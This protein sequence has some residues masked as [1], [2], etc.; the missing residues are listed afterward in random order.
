MSG[1]DLLR[2]SRDGDQ[3]HYYWAARQSL[4]LL[5]PGTSLVAIAIEGASDREF[6]VGQ[7]VVAGEQIID[8]AEYYGSEHLADADKVVYRQLKHSTVRRAEPWRLSGLRRTLC[9]FA[10]RYK[11]LNDDTISV[12]DKVRFKL[13]TNRPV[14]E[15]F[16][17]T[18]QDLAQN[19]KPRHQ[20]QMDLLR[21]YIQIHDDS[22]ASKFAQLLDLGTPEIDLGALRLE[23]EN[24]VAEFLPGMRGDAS[25]RL[26]ETVSQRATSLAIDSTIRRE[27]V[28]IALGATE[29]QLFPAPPLLT[30]V[31][32]PVARK[33]FHKISAHIVHAE[34]PVIVHAPGGVGKSVLAGSLQQLLPGGSVCVVYDCFGAG[35]YRRMSGPRHEHRQA[36]VQIVNEIA[37]RRL[38]QPLVPSPTATASD[39]TAAFRDRIQKSAAALRAASPDAVLVIA[40]D[41][42]DNA[43][44][45]AKDFNSGSFV[46]DLLAE[47][48][49]PGN[50]RLAVFARTER[51]D[52]LDPPPEAM[53]VEITGFS[54]QETAEHV[55]MKFADAK[56]LDISEFHRL[57]FGNPRVQAQVLGEATSVE[58]CLRLLAS[59]NTIDAAGT[60]DA[61]IANSV[62]KI[63]YEQKLKLSEVDS[64][65][66]SLAALRP[67]IPINFMAELCS[68]PIETIHSFVSDLGRPLLI[69]GDS[70]QFRDE[71]TETWFRKNHRPTSAKLTSFLL[72]LEPLA[73]KYTYAAACLPQLLWEAGQFAKLVQLAVNGS[74]LPKSNELERAEIEQQRL[75]FA[76]KSAAKRNMK[77]EVAKLALKAGSL[78]LGEARRR[79]LIRNN[80]HI[81]G[82]VLN[83]QIVDDLLARRALAVNWPGSNLAY[84]GCMLSFASGQLDIAR[85]RLRS[86]I[87]WMVGWSRL[88]EDVKD[89]NH[90]S[91]DDIAQV[92]LG[93]VNT[94]GPGAAVAFLSRWRP[95]TV[96]YRAGTIV[97]SRLI[98][99]NRLESLD[100]FV[101][102]AEGN[103]LLQLGI[104]ESAGKNGITIASEAARSALKRFRRRRKPI[105]VS[106]RRSHAYGDE[107][108]ALAAT[109]A[110]VTASA[111]HRLAKPNV[112]GRILKLQL[113]PSLPRG[114]GSRG[115][116][117]PDLLLK[118]FSLLTF[119]SGFE[120]TERNLAHPELVKEIE[121]PKHDP[122]NELSEFRRN[123]TPALP[124]AQLWA[125]VVC[126]ALS[127]SDP[128]LRRLSNDTY[129]KNVGDYQTPR[130]LLQM[131]ARFSAQILAQHQ[132]HYTAGLFHEWIRRVDRFLYWPTLIEIVQHSARTQSMDSVTFA[133]AAHL[134]ETL[135]VSREQASEKISTFAALAR[136]VRSASLEEAKAY[137]GRAIETSMKIGDEVLRRWNAVNALARQGSTVGKDDERAYQL[138]RTFEALAEFLGDASEQQPQCIQTIV[139]F[140]RSSAL[141]IAARWRDRRFGSA[142]HVLREI[143]DSVE[144]WGDAPL[145]V[146]SLVPISE[147]TDMRPI[148]ERLSS[149][150][151]IEPALLFDVVS[152]YDRGT[153]HHPEYFQ[154]IKSL[155]Q[156][157][158]IDL[159]TTSYSDNS[160]QRRTTTSR[161]Y[162]S[163]VSHRTS[164]GNDKKYLRSRASNI[165]ALRALDLSQP[166]DLEEARRMCVDRVGIN[167]ED[168]IDS[169]LST[170]SRNLSAVIDA[171]RRN[172]NFGAYIYRALIER[173][174]D[175]DG[176]PRAALDAGRLLATH[177]IHRFCEKIVTSSDYEVLPLE[178]LSRATGS[179][180]RDIFDAAL[181][182]LGARNETLDADTCFGLVSSIAPWLTGR[183]ALDCFDQATDELEYLNEIDTGDGPWTSALLPPSDIH[184][185]VAGY[186]WS[187]L[188]DPA[189]ATRWR[190]AH[191]VHLLCQLG[192]DGELRAL[193]DLAATEGSEASFTDARLKF[194]RLHA[195]LWLFLGLER[196]SLD[197][198]NRV[199]LFQSGLRSNA[200]GNHVLLRESARRSLLLLDRKGLVG[201]SEDER[202]HL[203]RVNSPV[204]TAQRHDRRPSSSQRRSTRADG[205]YRF[206]FDFEEHWLEPLARCFALPLESVAQ[207]ASDVITQSWAL[208][209]VDE[210]V[211]DSRRLLGI[212]DEKTSYYKSETPA[213]HAL[214]FYLSFHA[215]MVVAG[216]LIDT[217][218]VHVDPDGIDDDF[219]GWLQHFRPTRRDGRWLS[220][221]RDAIPPDQVSLQD[222]DALDRTWADN[223][224]NENPLRRLFDVEPPMIVVSEWSTQRKDGDTEAVSVSS[225]LVAPDRALHLLAAWQSAASPWHFAVPGDN[226]EDAL[227]AGS[228]R[229]L[230]WIADG[231]LPSRLDSSD[232]LA[233]GV[234]FPA[235]RPSAL[236]CRWLGIAG[237][238]DERNWY[239]GDHLLLSSIVWSDM[240]DVNGRGTGTDGHR[241]SISLDGLRDLTRKSGMS[242]IFK[243]TLERTLRDDYKH[244]NGPNDPDTRI[245]V[246]NFKV[247][248]F[249]EHD[250]FVEL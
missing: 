105:E 9:G 99:A 209:L 35:R 10:D 154:Q 208:P 119:F 1:T 5:V 85:S 228:Y 7:R 131:V 163:G 199:A 250:G 166:H 170:P 27:D 104:L 83:G 237:D 133:V 126:A 247:L 71:P 59:S 153:W 200:F 142:Y 149:S 78:S 210:R 191:S 176:L 44:M 58:E 15:Q 82:E 165:A 102:A 207:R 162:S 235:P 50:V 197:A 74:A 14:D 70:I 13:V 248:I 214:D 89:D 238:T 95:A 127:E 218:P 52:L 106:D 233:E 36:L 8:I 225:A 86:A 66:E 135:A 48:E 84:E 125:R 63:R 124:W 167:Y 100:S 114:I 236:A 49:M 243:V 120:M 109:I 249:D 138:A 26:K 20:V 113:P 161:P 215:L 98:E 32:N 56:D 51:V 143:M 39:Y 123:I 61:V 88:P 55:R 141:A 18:V 73:E 16:N 168:L 229:L 111:R 65:C 150:R 75:Q 179:S 6:P 28:L 160:I 216:D 193:A 69:D 213:V 101:V 192:A 184:R 189:E 2:A 30:P 96:A 178:L 11:A 169:T 185:C 246:P 181:I 211:E 224:R 202:I 234:Q 201:V 24:G 81:A 171:F 121:E 148:L 3:F 31:L 152:T 38:C 164:W 212:L 22:D 41:A 53:K 195:L 144:L 217:E 219:A 220:D 227:N 194:Y 172:D 231:S 72:R 57:T 223:V 117:A 91:D 25:L 140:S 132:D 177:A 174:L 232:P 244:W 23:Y 107:Y 190:A 112:L 37:G 108:P 147:S 175:T 92:A 129:T 139:R 173:I 226:D 4:S 45:A 42:A 68:L 12:L 43:V 239:R 187:A 47:D 182:E 245:P 155:A 183:E 157:F 136:S 21:R 204:G 103:A 180:S 206:Y 203:G 67:Q 116:S 33:Q 146:A 241:L 156:R 79:T 110:V 54:L 62:D 137:F 40:I 186:I 76:V 34:K 205:R 60:L 122:S 221:R 115:G 240:H 128:E 134:D 97:G 222:L 93:L 80:T 118:G 77:V 46:P 87:D 196:A 94:D 198:P 242:V 17:E 158:S 230:G 90:I 19:R 151:Q 145:G 64:I 188:A 29:D 130:V 159:S